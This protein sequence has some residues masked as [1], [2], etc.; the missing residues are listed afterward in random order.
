L[1]VAKQNNIT[2]G[3]FSF[4][5][6]QYHFGLFGAYDLGAAIDAQKQQCHNK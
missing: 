2:N 1:K 3:F 4:I 6:Y 5:D